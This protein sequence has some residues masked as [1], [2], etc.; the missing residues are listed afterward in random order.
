MEPERKRELFQRGIA[1]FNRGEFFTCHEVLE[2]IWLEEPEEE[3][4][5]YQ[6][7][8]QV[9]A[10]FHHFQRSNR[11][12]L[13]SLLRGGVEKLRRFPPDH[14]GLNLAALMT[15]LDPWLECLAKELPL[16]ALALPSI[17][18]KAKQSS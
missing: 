14:C 7:I 3:K 9:A 11:A 8:I 12:G 13:D 17:Q 6:G 1:L 16:E 2:E 18:M 5:F 10:A 15:A 4:P